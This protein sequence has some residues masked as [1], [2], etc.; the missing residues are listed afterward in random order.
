MHIV[1]EIIDVLENHNFEIQQVEEPNGDKYIELQ[2]H[3]PCGEDWHETIWFNGTDDD[4]VRNVNKRYMDFDV[5][6][7]VEPWVEKRGENGV[8]S[9][10]KALVEDAEWKERELEILSNELEEALEDELR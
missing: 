8:P 1:K 9:S 3:T 10:I 5:D 4:F 7:E 6:E 2:Q